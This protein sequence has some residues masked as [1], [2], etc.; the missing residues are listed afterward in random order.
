M[1]RVERRVCSSQNGKISASLELFACGL[2]LGDKAHRRVATRGLGGDARCRCGHG[3]AEIGAVSLG[4]KFCVVR[5]GSTG[6]L[7]GWNFGRHSFP[8]ACRKMF[9]TVPVEPARGYCRVNGPRG[10]GQFWRVCECDVGRTCGL[11]SLVRRGSEESHLSTST[12][13]DTDEVERAQHRTEEFPRCCGSSH[14]KQQRQNK[15][16]QPNPQHNHF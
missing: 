3:C 4:S 6:V 16:A 5:T 2:G 15:A 8:V 11:R 7:Q 13:A 9:C 12:L 10:P 1:E 14:V